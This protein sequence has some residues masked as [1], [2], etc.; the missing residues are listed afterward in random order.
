MRNKENLMPETESSS[1]AEAESKA[2]SPVSA[3]EQQL[4]IA[5]DYLNSLSGEKWDE[6]LTN[7]QGNMN[8]DNTVQKT[9]SGSIVIPPVQSP[10][11]ADANYMNWIM[12]NQM[13]TVSDYLAWKYKEGELPLVRGAFGAAGMYDQIPIEEALEKGNRAHLE[14]LE[15]MGKMREITFTEAP[16]LKMLGEATGLLPFMLASIKHGLEMGLV[17][18]GGYAG[19]AAWAGQ[20]PPLTLVPEEA[21]TIPSA[22]GAGLGQGMA[23]G[24]IKTSLDIE[25]GN[26]FLDLIEKGVDKKTAT[27]LA[28]GAGLAIGL[29]EVSQLK[30][31][32]A[33]IKL[34]FTKMIKTGTAKNAISKVL[35]S[36]FKTIGVQMGQEQLQEIIQIATKLLAG[37]IENNP[38]VAPTYEEIGKQLLETAKITGQALPV[39][40][41]PGLVIG[42]SFATKRSQKEIT[43]EEKGEKIS[44]SKQKKK[45]TKPSESERTEK[46]VSEDKDSI[47]EKQEQEVI[48]KEKALV[49][50][51]FDNIKTKSDLEKNLYIQDL[52]GLTEEQARDFLLT[53]SLQEHQEPPTFTQEEIDELDKQYDAMLSELSD[54]DFEKYDADMEK[55]YDLVYGEGAKQAFEDSMKDKEEIRRDHIKALAERAAKA[56]EILN[57]EGLLTA[58]N[59]YKQIL[60]SP[61]MRLNHKALKDLATNPT[62]DKLIAFLV[63]TVEQ[64]GNITKEQGRILRELMN[65][66]EETDPDLISKISDTSKPKTMQ[67]IDNWDLIVDEFESKVTDQEQLKEA[68]REEMLP[69]DMAIPEERK[70]FMKLVDHLFKNIDITQTPKDILWNAISKVFY[71]GDM[72][73]LSDKEL[74]NQTLQE[75]IVLTRGLDFLEKNLG[76]T[77]EELTE[78]E[79]IINAKLRTHYGDALMDKIVNLQAEAITDDLMETLETT[80]EKQDFLEEP[81]AFVDWEADQFE[82]RWEKSIEDR[83]TINSTTP[84]EL[85]KASGMSI[86]AAEDFLT[87]VREAYKEFT[88]YWETERKSETDEQA[89]F[90]EVGKRLEEKVN[91]YIELLDAL[92]DGATDFMTA[93][94]LNKNLKNTSAFMNRIR[95]ELIRLKH[96]SMH[97]TPFLTL[98]Q[99]GEF[100]IIDNIS[101]LT[102]TTPE[103]IAIGATEAEVFDNIYKTFIEI[104]KKAD[105]DQV[106]KEVKES[107]KGSVTEKGTTTFSRAENIIDLIED[108]LRAIG[109]KDIYTITKA[110][111]TEA[112][113]IF[114]QFIEAEEKGKNNDYVISEIKKFQAQITV[115]TRNNIAKEQKRINDQTS[116]LLENKNPFV[117]NA[118]IVTAVNVARRMISWWNRITTKTAKPV[119]IQAFRGIRANPFIGKAIN[120]AG[121]IGTFWSSTIEA[122]SYYSDTVVKATLTLKNPFVINDNESLFTFV[123]EV[124]DDKIFERGTRTEKELTTEEKINLINNMDLLT[125]LNNNPELITKWQQK[126]GYDSLIINLSLITSSE[127]NAIDQNQIIVFDKPTIQ[128]PYF[129]SP[130][131]TLNFNQE[132]EEFEQSWGKETTIDQVLKESL[133][134]SEEQI[135]KLSDKQKETL[136]KIHEEKEFRQSLEGSVTEEETTEEEATTEE[137]PLKEENP[138]DVYKKKTDYHNPDKITNEQARILWDNVDTIIKDIKEGSKKL[139]NDIIDNNGNGFSS[140]IKKAF[141]NFKKKFFALQPM[142]IIFDLLDT[143]KSFKGINYTLFKKPMNIAYANM[144]EHLGAIMDEIYTLHYEL[145][146]AE[147]NYKKIL[148]YAVL[149][150]DAYYKNEIGREKLLR[151]YSKEELATF[152]KEGLT[153]EEK[154]ML[155]LM[156]KHFD[157]IKPQLAEVMKKVYNKEFG[158][159][160]YYFSM[161]TDFDAME[162]WEID[163]YFGDEAAVFEHLNTVSA[164]FLK[165]RKGGAVPI[166]TNAF[167]VFQRHMENATYLIHMAE[168]IEKSLAIAR[169]NDY[170]DAVGEAGQTAVLDWLNL[171][172]RKGGAGSSRIRALDWLRENASVAILGYKL[173]TILIQPTALLDGA[174]LLQTKDGNYA[175]KGL[176]AILMSPQAS[177]WRTFI[178]HNS[179][180]I[181]KRTA[182]DPAFA[183]F[184]DNELDKSWFGEFKKHAFWGVRAVDSITAVAVFAGAYMKILAEKGKTVDLTTIDIDAIHEAELYVRRTQASA[185][186]IDLPAAVS[187]GGLTGNV[188]ID[189]AITQFQ[190]FIFTRASIVVQ[191]IG[192]N[193]AKNTPEMRNI[194]GFLTIALI[195][196]VVIR[197]SAQEMIGM[198]TGDDP[199]EPFIDTFLS[200]FGQELFSS[201]PI[202]GQIGGAYKYDS[203]PIPVLSLAEKAISNSFVYMSAEDKKEAKIYLVRSLLEF[204]GLFGIAPGAN[205]ADQILRDFHRIQK[206][207]ENT[208]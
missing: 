50:K 194:A 139:I 57:S 49:R 175:F 44:E 141:Y 190:T 3:H 86:S 108:R 93:L 138:S 70:N 41:L 147:T 87:R 58:W 39:L 22:F 172:A 15:E 133:N 1:S 23:F 131:Y 11:Q 35:K 91:N 152:E 26:L 128:Q 129:I 201:I 119:E 154:Q 53:T 163:K 189:K 64:T 36:Y 105:I 42:S 104:M 192:K 96:S 68:E 61:G 157:I 47:K 77:K 72:N 206:R 132:K 136:L 38:D 161:M 69:E 170:K 197:R 89:E 208:K 82:R 156:R 73:T 159:R 101:T 180:E 14:Q 186:S 171:L 113:K 168:I 191:S 71:P 48:A 18:G 56:K 167:Q 31:F 76:I 80:E 25:G 111:N 74:I 79:D 150:Q 196:E 153:A 122:A 5:E 81:D 102:S 29:I 178:K 9:P 17:F 13:P 158:A 59:Y 94:T 88:E 8:M 6:I 99:H 130:P 151:T 55:E 160:E 174:A 203:P 37:H 46:S 155:D 140:A 43:D 60:R 2:V 183:A 16:L 149:E 202:L 116:T 134:L 164:S 75:S 19:F 4:Q 114:N 109:I 12:D 142:D 112:K 107:L 146:L 177:A 100:F 30:L 127:I 126:K 166:K 84:E 67:E 145:Q 184:L 125:E 106:E 137:E 124:I 173:S 121:N 143:G 52:L 195:A 187:Q 118:K 10:A 65:F 97:A 204:A 40:G 90:K 28:I 95:Q 92:L 24:V 176:Y 185:Q 199:D 198:L 63:A 182:D 205:Q 179:T 200:N 162:Q 110:Q 62:A 51:I 45:E 207:K 98:M 85:A 165:E 169:T 188:S 32:T 144:G 120:F 33:P 34:A 181:K 148:V 115:H 27:P 20:I 21:V 103:I 83:E 123:K 193:G 66:I 78:L 117:T 135:N 7:E 54:E